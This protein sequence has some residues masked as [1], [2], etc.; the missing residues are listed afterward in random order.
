MEVCMKKVLVV[1]GLGFIGNNLSRYLISNRYEVSIIDN[2]IESDIKFLPEGCSYYKIDI[3]DRLD[4]VFNSIKPD[5]CFSCAA[6]AAECLSHWNRSYCADV[7]I[8]GTANIINQ[9]INNNVKLIHFSS[10]AAYGNSLNGSPFKETDPLIPEDVY[11]LTKKYNEDDIKTANE[12]FGLRYNIIRA[13]NV[14]GGKYQNLFSKYRNVLGIW[15]RQILWE[16][17]NIS[18]YSPGTQERSF[19]NVKY[20]LPCMEKL[21]ES[22]DN[23]TFNLGSRSQMSII[24]AANIVKDVANQ[25]GYKCEIEILPRRREIVIAY[26]DNSKAETMLGLNDKTNLTETF[27]E[28][29]EWGKTLEY[30]VPKYMDYEVEKGLYSYWKK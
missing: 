27:K 29:L 6:M 26:C 8:V 15:C 24:Q 3:R 14:V 23:E 13:Y 11:G 21:I 16:G 30:K 2:E 20:I 1:G 25:I 17:G 5:V 12:M 10:I 18:V 22:F 4:S 28:M 9:C 19:S 7:N